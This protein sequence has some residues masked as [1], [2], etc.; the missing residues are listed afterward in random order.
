[1]ST[2][3][4]KTKSGKPC[5]NSPVEGSEY[6]H[7]KGHRPKQQPASGKCTAKTSDGKPCSFSA[8]KDGLCG[9]HS[10]DKKRGRKSKLPTIDYNQ[11]EKLTRLGATDKELAD[12][13]EVTEQTINNWKKEDVQFFESLKRGKEIAD[14]EVAEKLYQRAIGYSHPEEKIFQYEGGIIRADTT[15]HYAPDT[16]AGIFWLKN[17]RPD[18]WRDKQDIDVTMRPN[19]W[20]EE[21]GDPL[22]YLNSKINSGR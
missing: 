1:M 17:R 19:E 4:A 9:I 15:K 5:K 12:F 14:A 2:C 10:T 6:C 18:K 11:V 21:K 7:I 3:K 22:D 20:D 13:Y 16:T 8:K